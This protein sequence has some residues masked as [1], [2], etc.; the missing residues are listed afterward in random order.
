MGKKENINWLWVHLPFSPLSTFTVPALQMPLYS[1][2]IE[3]LGLEPRGEQG[4]AWTGGKAG[5]NNTSKSYKTNQNLLNKINCA[6]RLK[7]LLVNDS[8][9]PMTQDQK[10]CFFS[11]SFFVMWKHTW[12]G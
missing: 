3:A 5:R 1:N 12:K 7:S 9:L 10:F 8:F 2:D 11:D 4:T 6:Q